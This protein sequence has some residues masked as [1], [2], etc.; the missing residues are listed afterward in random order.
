MDEDRF[1]NSTIIDK[2]INL[3]KKIIIKEKQVRMKQIKQLIS[4]ALYMLVI[5]MR[6]LHDILD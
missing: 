3:S 5:T 2:W 6:R 1:D 4:H